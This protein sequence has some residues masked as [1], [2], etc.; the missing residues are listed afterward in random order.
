MTLFSH[1]LSRTR[2]CEY[3]DHDLTFFMLVYRNYEAANRCLARLRSHFPEARVI[4]R[5]DGDSDQRHEELIDR[6]AVEYHAERRLFPVENGGAIIVRMLELYLERPTR[7][8]FKIDPDTTVH[9]RFR[10]LPAQE[11][12][13]GTLQGRRGFRSVQGGCMGLTLSVAENILASRL[14]ESEDLKHPQACRN[15][16]PYW[17]ILTRRAERVGLTSFDWSLGWAVSE[18][19]ISVLEFPEVYC[20]AKTLVDNRNLRYAITHPEP[21]SLLTTVFASAESSSL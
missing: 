14:L 10:Y 18:L 17:R 7:Y 9:R 4:V 11:A 16:S 6:Y 3:T 5:S 12:H 1:S 15:R 13:F 2:N 20:R 21:D 19:H 8:L